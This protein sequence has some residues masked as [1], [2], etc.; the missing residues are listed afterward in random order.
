MLLLLETGSLQSSW[1]ESCWVNI[2]PN[3]VINVPIRVD[4]ETEKMLCGSV[5]DCSCR[6]HE[7][8]SPDPGQAA[9]N[10]PWLL[11]HHSWGRRGLINAFICLQPNLLKH[12]RSLSVPGLTV[13]AT[14]RCNVK[15]WQN[16]VETRG[17]NA[18]NVGS[19]D[20]EIREGRSQ[21]SS[22]LRRG[23]G[24]RCFLQSF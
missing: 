23:L 8:G 7:F 1:N 9:H 17:S 24:S 18:T 3:P 15:L 6:K 11:R 14:E 16:T 4:S 5:I 2:V 22:F 20:K 21:R 12:Q 10:C 19:M 13:S